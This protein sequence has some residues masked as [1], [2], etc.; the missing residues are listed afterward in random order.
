MSTEA[1]YL[2]G[3]LHPEGSQELEDAPGREPDD[4]VPKTDRTF[5]RVLLPQRGHCIS[6]EEEIDLTY[7]SKSSPHSR[8]VYS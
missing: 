8:H 1:D 5:W 7:F 2:P 4:L 3:R 6:G